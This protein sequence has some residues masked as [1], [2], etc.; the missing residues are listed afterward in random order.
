MKSEYT[1][2]IYTGG[3]KESIFHNV[4]KKEIKVAGDN[5]NTTIDLFLENIKE[6][7]SHKEIAFFGGNFTELEKSKQEELL[8][9]AYKY[10][11]DGKLDSIR[12]STMP[13]NIDKDLLKMYKK[14]KV[15]TIE[16]SVQTSNNYILARCNFDYNFDDIRKVSKLIKKH[17]IGL[18]YQIVVGLP[19]STLLDELNT[20]R[21]L[22]KLKPDMVR[23][24]PLVVLKNTE[25]NR[26]YETEEFLPLTIGQAVERCKELYYV[27]NKKKIHQIYIGYKNADLMENV[28]ENE[29]VS[30]P[31][32]NAFDI[33]VEDNIWY[34][35]I[36]EKI[37]KFNVKV[38]EVEI[39][40]NPENSGNVI[41]YENE[42]IEKL[43]DLYEVDVVLVKDEQKPIGKFDIKIL[44][45]FTD[46]LEKTKT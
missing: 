44:K 5:I 4:E 25:L 7:N 40:V 10:I 17:R 28:K 8:S 19:E 26:L 43:K 1:I 27:F 37:K 36:V 18:G 41:G 3:S 38:K 33:L 21:D 35:S 14:Y 42:N 16:L 12:I 15:Q 46:F 13:K 30:G 22:I 31:Y 45:T 2:P 11:E 29:I 23:I 6:E 20:A 34:D 39:S 32:H 24:Y 9:T